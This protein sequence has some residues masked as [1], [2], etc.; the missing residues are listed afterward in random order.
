MDSGT[1]LDAE[2]GRPAAWT[3]LGEDWESCFP[4]D[5]SRIRAHARFLRETSAR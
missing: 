1:P 2:S 5:L 4:E 3:S